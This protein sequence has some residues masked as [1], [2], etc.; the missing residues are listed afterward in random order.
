MTKD[1]A[2]NARLLGQGVDKRYWV[3]VL[4]PPGEY[5]RPL[6]RGMSIRIKGQQ[7]QCLP[8]SVDWQ[9]EPT[10]L[11][12]RNSPIRFCLSVPD[13][14]LMLTLREGK[15]RQVRRMKAALGFLTLRLVRWPFGSFTL[16]GMQLG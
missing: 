3:Q 5:L 12:E 15:N 14:W 9:K 4:G 11:P 13:N 8:A 6:M 1:P 16:E 10:L 7:H 2:Q